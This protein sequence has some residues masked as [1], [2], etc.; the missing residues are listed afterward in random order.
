MR[1]PWWL[2]FLRRRIIYIYM[3]ILFT[4]TLYN[5]LNHIHMRYNGESRTTHWNG[6]G[7]QTTVGLRA[8][9]LRCVL[10]EN[11]LLEYCDLMWWHD[12]GSLKVCC[13]YNQQRVWIYV[14]RDWH[15]I[16]Q[17]QELIAH[18]EENISYLLLL[19]LYIR[20]WVIMTC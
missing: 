6:N 13:M 9:A 11:R 1:L 19:L 14:F 4:Y 15:Q 2:M 3:I 8:F 16:N 20:L 5:T 12:S 7:G 10:Y 17:F 18:F